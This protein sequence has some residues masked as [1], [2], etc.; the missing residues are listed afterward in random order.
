MDSVISES[1]LK[2]PHKKKFWMY[3]PSASMHLKII[4]YDNRLAQ[5]NEKIL[6]TVTFKQMWYTNQC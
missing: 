4:S 2:I 1:V 3:D 6:V 5:D